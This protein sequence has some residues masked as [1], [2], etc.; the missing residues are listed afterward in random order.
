MARKCSK[1]NLLGKAVEYTREHRLRA[2]QAGLKSFIGGQVDGPALVEKWLTVWMI[3]FGE[4][5]DEIEGEDGV[6]EDEVGEEELGKKRKRRAKASP[7]PKVTDDRA[8]KKSVSPVTVP[9]DQV[10]EKKRGRSRK[11]LPSTAPVAP[12]VTTLPDQILPT[13]QDETAQP[14]FTNESQWLQYQQLQQ[15]QSLLAV[16]A[17]FSSFNPPLTSSSSVRQDHHH[18]SHTGTIF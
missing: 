14:F 2:E 7:V 11:V 8:T 9:N 16:F 13:K 17:L 5:Q 15:Q 1:A 4:K 18:H 6:G 3:K 12:R 10:P